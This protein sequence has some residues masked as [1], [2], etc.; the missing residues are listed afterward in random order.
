MSSVVHLQLGEALT[1]NP[2]AVI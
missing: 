1:N 2:A